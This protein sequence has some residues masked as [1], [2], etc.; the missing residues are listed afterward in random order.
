MVQECSY[1]HACDA[2]IPTTFVHEHVM[3]T[4]ECCGCLSVT[5]YEA[6][7]IVATYAVIEAFDY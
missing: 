4:H 6:A 3:L 2:Q 7:Y 1:C 5:M